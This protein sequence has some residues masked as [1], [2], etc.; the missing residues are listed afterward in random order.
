MDKFGSEGE[1]ES[2]AVQLNSVAGE[3]KSW[4]TVAPAGRQRQEERQKGKQTEADR[5]RQRQTEAD[6]GRAKQ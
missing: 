6:R 2:V 3:S 4:T 5:G 1:S